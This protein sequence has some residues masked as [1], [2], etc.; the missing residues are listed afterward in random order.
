M[1]AID[2]QRVEGGV[3]CRAVVER[4]PCGERPP[5]ACRIIVIYGINYGH[6]GGVRASKVSSEMYLGESNSTSAPFVTI[7]LANFDA[8]T[9]SRQIE[10]FIG[11][12]LQIM[13]S[14]D[15]MPL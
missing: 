1:L 12:G 13:M 7:I 8:E 4:D 14:K 5:F 6:D 9:R 2:R 11:V 15:V 10:N 3:L